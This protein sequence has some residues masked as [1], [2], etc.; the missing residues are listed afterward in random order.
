MLRACTQRFIVLSGIFGASFFTSA[1]VCDVCGQS[2]CECWLETN[3]SRPTDVRNLAP[4][5]PDDLQYESRLQLRCSCRVWHPD[6]H[7]LL[8]LRCSKCNDVRL[9]LAS[10][11][12]VDLAKLATWTRDAAKVAR[13][14][15]VSRVCL[16]K[17]IGMCVNPA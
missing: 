4:L 1:S 11:L 9:T 12:G 6:S 5:L 14:N 10:S 7:V 17:S 16:A 8:A 2:R 3:I 13:V 15:K